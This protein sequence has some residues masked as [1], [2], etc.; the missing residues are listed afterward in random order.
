MRTRTEYYFS[1]V[2][3]DGALLTPG[4]LQRADSLDPELGGMS[5]KD[6]G[7]E[8]R[9]HIKEAVLE[10]WERLRSLFAPYG[11]AAGQDGEGRGEVSQRWIELLLRELAYTQLERAAGRIDTSRFPISHIWKN[12]PI[13]VVAPNV[14]LDQRTRGVP[15]AAR[16]SPHATLQ[17][18]LNSSE[19]YLY[20]LL[21]NGR[22]LRLLRRDLSLM[23]ASYVEF[24]V[25]AMF[26]SG[27][28]ADFRLMWLICHASRLDRD[29]SGK[30]ILE[31]WREKAVEEG[32]RAMDSLRQAAMQALE[33]LGSGFLSNPKNERLRADLRSGSLSKLDFYRQL[34]RLVYRFIFLFCAEDRGLL[35]PPD[36]DDFARRLYAGYYSTN[37]LRR[38]A[39][40]IRGSAHEDL[41]EQVKLVMRALEA[42]KGAAPVL[43]LPALGSF[44]WSKEAV[45]HLD[46][47]YLANSSLLEAVR[48]L[49]FTQ[50]EGRRWP[51]D[52]RHMG[53][54]ELGSVYES[55]LEYEPDLN[56]EANSFSLKRLPGHERRTTGSY[57]TPPV[58]VDSLIKST[59]DPVLK[60][61]AQK[62]DPEQAILSLK[63]CDPA[64]G[65]G[66]FLVAA[67]RR[68]AERLASVRSGEEI[69]PPESYRKS[70][71]DVVS[72]CLYGVDLNEMAVELC[73]VALWLEALDPGRPL[74][75]LDGH[76]KRGNSLIGATPSLLSRPLPSEAFDKNVLD[77][78]AATSALRKRN[79]VEARRWGTDLQLTLESAWLG[80]DS[81]Q[82]AQE[83]EVLP[84]NKLAAIEEKDRR[85][86]AYQHHPEHL[87][88]KMVADAWCAA[89]FIPRRLGAQG[90][91]S[92]V[93]RRIMEDPSSVPNELRLEIES[94]S[95]KVGF[96]HWH[97]EFPWVFKKNGPRPEEDPG[98]AGGFDVALGNPPW[99]RLKFQ[100]KEFFSSRDEMIAKA[101]TAA[102][103]KYLINDL[104]KS[105][106][107]LWD[108]YTSALHEARAASSFLRHS[109]R[110]PRCGKGDVN[111]YAVF[112][113]LFSQIIAHD[114]KAG[115]IVP[116]NIATD[117]TT[118]EFFSYLM[119]NQRLEVLLDFEN[120]AG[121]FPDVD[122]RYRFA[123]LTINDSGLAA[124][125]TK[126]AFLLQDP[127]E[128]EDPDRLISLTA[129]DVRKINPNTLTLPVTQTK[130]DALLLRLIHRR[131]PVL[132]NKEAGHNP[133]GLRFAR[134]FDMAN[135]SDLFKTRDQLERDGLVL[136]GNV[137]VR[138]KERYLPL[139]E[140]KMIHHFDHR[141]GTYEG[142]ASSSSTQLPRPNP[143]QLS[144]PNFAVLPRYW[145]QES[146]VLSWLGAKGWTH[147]WLMGWRD[148]TNATNRRTVIA[149]LI[150]QAAAGNK[151]FLALCEDPNKSA[152]LLACYCSLALDFA[153]RQKIVGTDLAFFIMEQMP[154][155]APET[156]ARP[157][158]WAPQTTIGAWTEARVLELVYTTHD[159]ASFA[160]DLGYAGPPFPYDAS[161]RDMIM[162]ELDAC[163]FHIYLGNEHSWQ[164][165]ADSDLKQ[166]F[167]EPREAV[168]HIL[169]SFRSLAREEERTYGEYRTKRLVLE[170]YEAMARCI[171]SGE[172]YRTPLSPPP[173]TP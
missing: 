142:K 150:P 10:S 26:A 169:N 60:R 161:R 34:Q 89:F 35:H 139:Y 153:A 151:F 8:G 121:L 6:Y 38:M 1:H 21:T 116:T 53:S 164:T 20:G 101:N 122:R 107:R 117:Y 86:S 87:R 69:P 120:R 100:E 159:L 163:F 140:A 104:K 108:A 110:F 125:E 75:F 50:K 158:P 43:G 136:S 127:S 16:S 94:Q 144:D 99:E 148:I 98:W 166:A 31:A 134:M 114:G 149:S 83:A 7:L 81:R 152:W 42:G 41:W 9:R 63:V 165:E 132:I 54:E 71:R 147:S 19:A 47:S 124:K 12:V 14:P 24:E 138:G 157:C 51:V 145:V 130:K 115:M 88:L 137:F 129:E 84:D 102:E 119:K 59:L 30:C 141:W 92:D 28:F 80:G 56:L 162:A 173:G 25:E 45:W 171:C 49:A 65:S 73:K 123:L 78:K 74:S 167:P 76:I 52:Y 113:E 109:G 170:S 27:S 103:R 11:Q 55:L 13:H 133:W 93:I 172:A 5:P 105:D 128:A 23:R 131:I 111:T 4:V 91:T 15:G 79:T 36:A 66:H 112:A 96:F 155:P 62:P 29:A 68:I 70:L 160:R 126:F 61:A 40:A 3:L 39:S 95:K 67:A 154:V 57:Y 18:L 168:I 156:F 22:I 17:S 118:S 32:L 72:R 58:L 48:L 82:V 46:Q 44:L 135:D 146:E 37:R 77:D 33:V 64:C 90:I 143:Q 85:L 106:P 97:L 2:R